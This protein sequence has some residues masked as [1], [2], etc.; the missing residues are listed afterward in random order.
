MMPMSATMRRLP[1]RDA[2][3]Q[4]VRA[5]AESEDRDVGAE[6]G[7]EELAGL[8]LALSLGDDVDAVP[9]NA[10]RTGA[11]GTEYF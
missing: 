4:D 11:A 8:A 6:P 5:V 10:Q 1:E 3:A 2:E 9:F 7:P